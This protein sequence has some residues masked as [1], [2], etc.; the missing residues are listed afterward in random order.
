MALELQYVAELNAAL[1]AQTSDFIAR[2]MRM[3]SGMMT[4]YQMFE[5]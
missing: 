2:W 1:H 5:R 3:M 4:P